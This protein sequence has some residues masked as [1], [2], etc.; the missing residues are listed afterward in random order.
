[1][2]KFDLLFNCNHDKICAT[3]VASSDKYKNAPRQMKRNFHE[4]EKPSYHLVAFMW[5]HEKEIVQ[6]LQQP[7]GGTF[8]F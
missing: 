7:P 3:T 8:H 5:A 4:K 6:S 2:S 1:M